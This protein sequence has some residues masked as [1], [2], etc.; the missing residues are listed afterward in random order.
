M[1]FGLIVDSSKPGLFQQ[2]NI[3]SPLA[4]FS[5]VVLVGGGDNVIH[6]K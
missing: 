4:H 3:T 2:A 6:K 1:F 5:N